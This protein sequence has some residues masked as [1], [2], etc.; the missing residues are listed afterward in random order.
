MSEEGRA[1]MRRAGIK[2]LTVAWVLLGLVAFLL[3][4]VVAFR[5]ARWIGVIVGVLLPPI[6]LLFA[7]FYGAFAQHD[8]RPLLATSVA[9]VVGAILRRYK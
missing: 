2:A 9:C 1:A 4:L 6:T 8:W 7:P 5:V 3:D